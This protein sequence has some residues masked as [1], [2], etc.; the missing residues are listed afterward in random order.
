VDH[1]SIINSINNLLFVKDSEIIKS[2]DEILS[3]INVDPQY[4]G[5]KFELAI[6]VNF[7]KM[8]N[9][10]LVSSLLS[11]KVLLPIFIAFKGLGKNFVDLINS[12]MDFVKEVSQLVINLTSKIGALFIKELF[13][14]IRKDIKNLIQQIV[15]DIQKEKSDKKV[16]MV[17]KLIQLLIVVAE[18]INDWRRCK[19]VVDEILWLLKIVVPNSGTIPL[20][21][22]FA[23]SLLDGYSE[24]RAFIGTIEEL[25]KLGVPTGNMPDGSPNLEL[26]SR[27]SQMKAMANED[28]ENGK[29]AVGIPPLTITPAGLTIPAPASGKKF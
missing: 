25:Q 24:T 21:L 7:V 1:D 15:L 16:L 4:N 27:L 28:A 12:F 5:I 14:L 17:L 8:I 3:S 26:L 18:I 22:L 19:S 6:N 20:P 13:E 9:V 2:V 23:S 10:G 29:V 11:P